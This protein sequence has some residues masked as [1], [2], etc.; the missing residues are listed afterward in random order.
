MKV[1]LTHVYSTNM[2]VTCDL[3]SLWVGD[4]TCRY[5]TVSP[6]HQKGFSGHEGTQVCNLC[7]PARTSPQS[8]ILFG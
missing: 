2:H 8:M 1:V 4:L 5:I 3:C 6:I 7:R